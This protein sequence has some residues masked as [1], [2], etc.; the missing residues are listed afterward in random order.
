M[1]EFNCNEKLPGNPIKQWI[2]AYY[3]EGNGGWEFLN[4][5]KDYRNESKELYGITFI[6]VGVFVG[7]CFND[8]FNADYSLCSFDEA[9]AFSKNMAER[10]AYGRATE[11]MTRKNRAKSRIYEDL[12]D[13][14]IKFIE[15][16]ERYYKGA[17]PSERVSNAKEQCKK[18]LALDE[19]SC[20][21]CDRCEK[22]LA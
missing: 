19:E 6:P 7:V 10:I 14:Y 18:I 13:S 8:V 12:A 11:G 2:Y 17:T 20:E 21:E 5:D 9:Y 15:R 3:E 22:Y 16:C 1:D 4:T